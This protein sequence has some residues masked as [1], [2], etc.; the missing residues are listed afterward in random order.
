MHHMQLTRSDAW[1]GGVVAACRLC[2]VC[3]LSC[4]VL[5]LGVGEGYIPAW[6]IWYA[7]FFTTAA[8]IPLACWACS[9]VACGPCSWA[10]ERMP[11]PQVIAT[12]RR[13]REEAAAAAAT[14]AKTAG[15]SVGVVWLCVTEL[16][17]FTAAL[18][19]P[20]YRWFWIQSFI[21]VIGATFQGVFLFFWFEDCFY[22]PCTCTGDCAGS[23][24]ADFCLDGHPPSYRLFGY[25]VTTSVQSAVAINGMVGSLTNAGV[26][27]TGNW[28]R[29]RFGGRQM[30]LLAGSVGLACPFTYALFTP[31]FT[32][33]P[34]PR[35]HYHDRSSGLTEIYLRFEI[36]ILILTT[37]A[38]ASLDLCQLGPGRLRGRCQRCHQSR[39]AADRQQRPAFQRSA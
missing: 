17:E 25:Q 20:P 18:R 26:S 38:G 7:Y 35:H 28:W 23:A 29:D 10:P 39:R 30:I 21:G 12:R 8:S 36:P 4:N 24:A 15:G 2:Q 5:G 37:R 14:A 6:C 11:S 13:Q 22:E 33:V 32:L 31:S 19:H 27:W 3:V 9:G 16:R 34:S 1:Y